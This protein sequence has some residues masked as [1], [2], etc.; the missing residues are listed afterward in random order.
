MAENLIPNIDDLNLEENSWEEG[1]L[2]IIQIVFL[3]HIAELLQ[4]NNSIVNII[5]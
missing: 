4:K 3:S 1:Y 5:N 2:G